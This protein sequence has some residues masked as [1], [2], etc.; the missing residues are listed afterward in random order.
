M[1]KTTVSRKVPS[2]RRVCRRST[3]SRVAPS[4]AMAAWE[5]WLSRSVWILHPPEAAVLE[6][7]RQEQELHLRADR[8][9]PPARAVERPAEVGALVAEVEVA[10]RGRAHDRSSRPE[11][12][13]RHQPHRVC[14]SAGRAR[15]DVGLEAAAGLG[16]VRRRGS[17]DISLGVDHGVAEDCMQAL[18]VIGPGGV[19]PDDATDERQSGRRGDRHG[20]TLA[21]GPR[22][23]AVLGPG[24][25]RR[26]VARGSAGWPDGPGRPRSERLSRA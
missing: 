19:Q 9:A 20:T 21:R 13:V 18:G 23:S 7:V 26:P 15:G 1:L 4:L 12:A 2:W 6:G 22:P 10:Q 3:P 14:R 5:R 11:S 25:W 24:D 17:H 16:Q 8:R